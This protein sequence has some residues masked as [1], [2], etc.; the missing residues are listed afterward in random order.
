MPNDLLILFNLPT[1]CFLRYLVSVHVYSL[2]LALDIV[3]PFATIE[4]IQYPVPL[5]CLDSR[6]L[7]SS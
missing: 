3:C 2:F 6:F 1:T 5:D 4:T 7:F